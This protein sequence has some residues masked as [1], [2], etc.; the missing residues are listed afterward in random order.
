M[1]EQ[2]TVRG[3]AGAIVWGYRTAAE[4]TTWRIYHHKPDGQH[5]DRWVLTAMLARVDKFQLRQRPLVF[6]AARGAGL[7]G[8]W[9]WPLLSATIAADDRQLTAQLGPPQH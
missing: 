5:D 1:F 7:K 9:M 8:L 6:T 4:L 3:R 2:I